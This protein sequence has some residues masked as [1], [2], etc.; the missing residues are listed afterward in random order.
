MTVIE[1]MKEQ[2]FTQVDMILELKRRG[3]N[4]QPPEMSSA[5]RGVA[6]YPKSK[7]IIEAVTEILD[8]KGAASCHT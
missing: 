4:V 2:G 3:L 1:R 8:E 6:T 7:R 5:L